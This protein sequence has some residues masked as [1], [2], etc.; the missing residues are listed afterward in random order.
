[1]RST[2]S[3]PFCS[4]IRRVSGPINGFASAAAFSVSHSL[5]A[6]QHDIDRTDRGRIIGDLGVFQMQIAERAFDL[7]PALADGV[8]MRAARD[9]SAL[10]VRR[11]PCARRNIRRRRPPPSLQYA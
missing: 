10:R 9:E 11:R 2:L 1:M 4:V 5:T 7:E 3:T 6:K 8:E